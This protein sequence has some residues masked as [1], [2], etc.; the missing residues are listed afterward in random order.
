MGTSTQLDSQDNHCAQFLV[1]CFA[2]SIYFPWLLHR[3][4]VC[5]FSLEHMLV[6]LE[7]MRTYLKTMYMRTSKDPKNEQIRKERNGKR[8]LQAR[9]R[10]FASS[11]QYF[12][13]LDSLLALSNIMMV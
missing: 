6:F 12:L 10:E 1:L 8:E 2:C 9:R 3:L 5:A 13:W 11:L 7:F 4:H